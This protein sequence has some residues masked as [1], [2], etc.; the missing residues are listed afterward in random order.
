MTTSMS[1][2]AVLARC[3][4]SEKFNVEFAEKCI[5]IGMQLVEA[6]D[7]PDVRKCAYNLFG[8]VATIVKED[9]SACM[10]PCVTLML[11]SLQSTEGIHLEMSGADSNLPLEEL[12]DEE[13]EINLEDASEEAED[14]DDVKAIGVENAFVAEKEQALVA[15]KDFSLECGPAFFPFLDPC[16]E[17]SWTMLDYPDDDVRGAAVLATAAFLTAYYKSGRP[18]GLKAFNTDT[19]RFIPKLAEM[20]EEESEHNVVVNSLDGI[21]EM[22]KHCKQAVTALPGVPEKIVMCVTKIMKKECACQDQD[23][24]EEGMEEEE[25]AEQDEMLF[26]YAGEVLP[27][28]GNISS[29]LVQSQSGC[30]QYQ[31]TCKNIFLGMAFNLNFFYY[32]D[33]N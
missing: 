32:D 23:D 15:L 8:A 27:N 1:T 14:L 7:D 6:N 30:H 33:F 28:L 2:L 26:E 24:E 13:D 19:A 18:E 20:V 9:M 16:I 31:L 21:T 3:V 12:D 22:L 29:S 11:K 5:T 4:G 25:E 10:E 17:E